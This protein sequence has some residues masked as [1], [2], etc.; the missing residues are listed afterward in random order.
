MNED[1]TDAL[2]RAIEHLANEMA[3]ARPKPHPFEQAG[4]VA[5]TCRECGQLLLTG[6]PSEI[7]ADLAERMATVLD[8][9]IGHG[10]GRFAIFSVQ[11]G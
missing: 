1:S 8:H 3:A 6:M 5:I 4:W 9:A 11:I 7:K 2:A 10:P